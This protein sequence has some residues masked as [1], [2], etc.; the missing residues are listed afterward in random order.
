MAPF[1]FGTLVYDFQAIDV[2]GPFDLLNSSSKALLTAMS[3]Y[4]PIDEKVLANAPDMVFH[5]IGE[6]LEPVH[7][8]TSNITIVPS[9][10]VDDAPELDA[11]L[12]GGPNPAGFKLSQK[13]I[14][15]I[16]RHVASGKPIFSTCT[17]A[18]VI[19][20]TGVLDG[21]NA[22]INNQEFH[23]TKKEFPK[24]KWT[25]DKKWVVD[26]NIWTGSG[27]V[28]GMDMIAHWIKETYGLDV[29]TQGASGLDY[30]PRDIDGAYDT[31]L[32]Q[33]YDASGKRLPAHVFP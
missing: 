7:L 8:L 32:K 20:V 17:G 13:Y 30:E 14:D 5:H 22:T 33:R 21:R 29:L 11:L 6:T 24:V 31:V 26:G 16:R 2:V 23:W 28:A 15:F 27:A 4:I 10:T 1:H 3:Y 19:A 18:A 9:T 12:I 25:K